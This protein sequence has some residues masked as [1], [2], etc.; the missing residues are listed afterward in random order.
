MT[1]GAAG[2]LNHEDIDMI[3]QIHKLAL[4]CASLNILALVQA[5]GKLNLTFVPTAKPGTDPAMA[6]PFSLCDTPENLEAG[7][8]GAMDKIAASRE[9]LEEQAFATATVLQMATKESA[10]KGASALQGNSAKQP[11]KS[12]PSIPEDGEDD[13]E[14]D[15]VPTSSTST[16]ASTA[17]APGASASVGAMNLFGT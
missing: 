6:Q 8:A 15:V 17:A 3:K 2:C 11:G 12:K 14:D 13:A 1:S 16:A 4:T 5:D 10:A 7:L 9:T